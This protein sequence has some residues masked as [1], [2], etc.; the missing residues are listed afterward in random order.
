[1]TLT[2]EPTVVRLSEHPLQRCGARSVAELAGRPS[3]DRVTAEDLESVAERIVEDVVAAA[4]AAK[5]SAA[6]DW[7]KVLF[8]LY[9]NSKPTHAKRPKDPEVLRREVAAMF[10]PDGGGGPVRP[11]AFCTAA[12]TV[13]WA[14]AALPMFD[15]DRVL[16]TLPTGLAGWPVCRPCRV[17]MWALPYGAWVTAGW[18]AVLTSDTPQVERE[19]VAR[20]TV[21]ALRI[22]QLGF[23]TGSAGRGPEAAAVQVL[24]PDV[25]EQEAAATLW[26]FKNDNQ[27]PWLQ[28]RSTRSG[29]ARFL[30]RMLTDS[31]CRA[32]WRELRQV[33]QRRDA[34]GRV[35]VD[36]ATAAARTLFDPDLQPAD[37]LVSQLRYQARE[38]GRLSWQTLHQW[39]AL[40]AL[41]LEVMYGVDNHDL[42]PVAALLAEWITADSSRGRFNEYRRAA[43][44][45]Y[46]LHKV[47]MNA[48]GRLTLDDPRRVPVPPEKVDEVVAGGGLR[49]QARCH[50]WFEVLVQLHER[51]ASLATGEDDEA[52]DEA[53]MRHEDTD[54]LADEEYA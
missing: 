51:G 49:W 42:K 8:A 43:D 38:P 52:G 19:F 32:G 46:L 11:C 16:N 34:S 3:P 44:H 25:A 22:Q 37:R 18:A 33:M 48:S 4:S 10:A 2:P 6:Y 5:S 41:Y 17:A 50:L 47:L 23:D 26:V 53:P 1:M 40:S 21:R 15:S 36:G 12:A 13:V 9:P 29:T 35:Q 24:R 45:G 14:K 7:W 20:N 54:P 27:E 31:Q 30:E 39:R 28:V